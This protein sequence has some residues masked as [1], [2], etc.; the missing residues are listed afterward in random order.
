MNTM[1]KM[2][3]EISIAEH[4]KKIYTNTS[5]SLINEQRN[6]FKNSIHSQH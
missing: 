4:L 5:T 6:D 3:D 1:T 2:K